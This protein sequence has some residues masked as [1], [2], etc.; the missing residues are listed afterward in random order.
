VIWTVFRIVTLN[1]G[2]NHTIKIFVCNDDTSLK[3]LSYSVSTIHYKTGRCD[4]FKKA[5][6]KSIAFFNLEVDYEN[7]RSKLSNGS[8]R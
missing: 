7:Y 8:R 5:M 4:C 1:E 6:E 3:L 2:G